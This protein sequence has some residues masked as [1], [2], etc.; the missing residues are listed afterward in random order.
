MCVSIYSLLPNQGCF[1][2]ILNMHG[3]RKSI[4]TVSHTFPKGFS[5][6][7]KSEL[8]NFLWQSAPPCSISQLN[9]NSIIIEVSQRKLRLKGK[10]QIWNS[11]SLR[12]INQNTVMWTKPAL[13]SCNHLCSSTYLPFILTPINSQTATTGYALDLGYIHLLPWTLRKREPGKG[14]EQSLKVGTRTF[15]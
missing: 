4:W 10:V 7:H 5:L 12:S 9:P 14:Y 15:G 2:T 6:H 11:H 13:D 8:L 3:P 1:H